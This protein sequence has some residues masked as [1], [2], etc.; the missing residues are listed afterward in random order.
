MSYNARWVRPLAFQRWVRAA[1]A[2]PTTSMAGQV[3]ALWRKASQRKATDEGLP[4]TT[5]AICPSCLCRGT[6][7]AFSAG[8]PSATRTNQYICLCRGSETAFSARKPFATHT[9]RHLRLCRD[10]RGRSF[11]LDIST[12]RRTGHC[13]KDGH[14]RDSH[15]RDG[16]Q[17]RGTFTAGKTATSKMTIERITLEMKT[18]ECGYGHQR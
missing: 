5:R 8:K 6:K 14:R 10:K 3:R 2:Y 4:A 16:H 15:Q 9:K 11:V 7:T 18:I 17:A 1:K 13:Q 12:A